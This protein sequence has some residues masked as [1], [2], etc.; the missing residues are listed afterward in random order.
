MGTSHSTHNNC[1]LSW[2]VV[3]TSVIPGPCVVYTQMPRLVRGSLCLASI[4]H[5]SPDLPPTEQPI[6]SPIL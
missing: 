6:D 3:L 1:M 2:L 4:L 5:S